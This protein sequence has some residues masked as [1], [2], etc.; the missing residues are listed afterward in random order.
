MV[1]QEKV[2]VKHVKGINIIA[3]ALTKV[4]ER[5]KLADAREKLQL[6]FE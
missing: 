2:F 5:I 4:L 1:P 6:S 3:Y